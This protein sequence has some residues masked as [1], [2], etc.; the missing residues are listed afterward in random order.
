M[1]KNGLKTGGDHRVRYT[2][3]I[4]TDRLIELMKARPVAEISVKEIC[5]Q[6]DVSRSTF[7]SHYEDVYHL[8]AEIEDEVFAYFNDMVDNISAKC[9]NRE[10]EAIFQKML[11]YI[12][13]NDNSIQVLLSANGDIG[14]QTKFFRRFIVYG[15]NMLQDASEN[16]NEAS[17]HEGCSVFVVHGAVGLLQYWLK[18]NMHIPI[19]VLAKL[20][21]KLTQSARAVY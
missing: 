2:R 14:F 1:V 8:L 6:A 16:P 18:H 5:V 10:F 17:I 19:P 15:R 12:A 3:K 9:G 21:V 13:D 4:L 11:Q 7:Y 20:L